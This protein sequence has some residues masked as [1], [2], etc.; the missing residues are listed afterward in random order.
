MPAQRDAERGT[1]RRDMPPSSTSAASAPRSSC[2]TQSTTECPPTSSSAVER[3]ADGSP[4]S[5]PAAARSSRRLEQ[6]EEVRLVVG[7]AA[8]D[9]PAV[10][11]GELEGVGLPELERVGRLDV[12][13]RVAEDGRRGTGAGRRGDL[14]DDER[15]LAP[16][17]DSA[18]AARRTDPLGDPVRRTAR[19]RPRAPGRR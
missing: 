2:S 4:G 8:G 11:L 18:V 13:V 3:E 10:T 6:H 7:D 1:S 17:I 5:S 14:A 16:L 9:E 19:R 12:E 15:P